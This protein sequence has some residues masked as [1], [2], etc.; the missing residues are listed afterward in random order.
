MARTTDQIQ[1]QIVANFQ[2]D[3]YLSSA[4]STSNR[5]YWKLW[6][7]I[8]AVAENQHEQLW[9][10]LQ[11]YLETIIASASPGT[12]LW[13]QAMC[14]LF[15]YDA[16]TPQIIQ[17]NTSTYAPYY[18]TVD[19]TKRIITR[20]SVTPGL[21][22]GTVSIKVAKGS[23][24]GALAAG[25]L[26][27]LQAYINPPNGIGT[28]GITYTITSTPP[29][30]LYTEADIY[31]NGQYAATILADIT[32]AYN[33]FLA[34]ISSQPNFGGK[35]KLSDLEGVLR[36]VPGVNDVAL[37]NI[38]A[39]AD[40]VAYGSGTNLVSG[41]TAL[42]PTYLMKA[43]YIIGETTSGHTLANSLNLIAQ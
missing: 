40:G 35:M 30:Q 17:F 20:C 25:E 41:Y 33:N 24:P 9:D 18:P 16:T 13:L 38:A 43:G 3:P 14:F 12:P 6:T 31:Y 10:I 34:L 26:S 27:A 39:R 1:D 42:I 22:A 5:A 19:I 2:A 7:R 37:K 23:T 36:N 11:S 29:D 8:A 21:F 32:T 4:N 28:N 15:Q